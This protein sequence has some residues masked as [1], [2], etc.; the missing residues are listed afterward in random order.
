MGG[1]LTALVPVRRGHARGRRPAEGARAAFEANGLG[2]QADSWVGTGANEPISGADVA[3][4]R[5]ATTSWRRSRASSA[6]RRSEAA[7]AVAAGAAGGRRQ[8]SPDGQLPPASEL[9]SAFGELE[10]LGRRG[11]GG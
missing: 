3:Q 9:D 11:W 4:G 10:H 2:A 1:L 7:A 8:V 5:S 6:S